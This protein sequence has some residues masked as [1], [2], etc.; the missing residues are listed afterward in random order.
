VGVPFPNRR[1]E[2]S[3]AAVGCFVNILP[4]PIDRRGDPTFLDL[5]R[6]V[7]VTLL[8]HHRHQE[9]PLE[10]I[11][12][13]C[14]P[15][16]DPGRN[17]L[18]QA[19]FTF[20][21]PVDLALEGAEVESSRAH[22]GGAQLDVFMDLWRGREGFVGELEYCSDLF[23][24]ATIER[25]VRNYR[26]LLQRALEPAAP[27]IPVS[28]LDLVHPSERE[29]V[30]RAWNATS[31][32]RGAPERLDLM[33]LEQA[34]RAPDATALR[35]GSRRW[36]YRELASRARA[37][38]LQLRSSGVEPGARVGLCM[39][40]SFE[41][42]TAMLATTM[43][44]GAYVPIDPEYPAHR[45]QLVLEDAR[46][47][48]VLTDPELPG[49]RW[50]PEGVEL[51]PVRLDG[52]DTVDE[53][54][55]ASSSPAEAAYVI[56]TSGSTGRPKGA[57]NSHR[58]IAN[59]IL[60][61]QEAFRLEPSDV[62]LQKTPYGF[63]VSVWE[64]FWPLCVGAQLE[65]A[66]PGAH[67]DPGALARLIQQAGV[68]TVHFV[69]S[70]LAAFL[71]HPGAA[72]CRTLRRIVCSGEAL[73]RE[74][75]RRCCKL[76]D[77][78][79]DNLYGPTEAA[80]DVSWWRC[81]EDLDR[82]PVPIGR[83]IAN[84]RLYVLDASGQPVPI[85]VPGELHIGGV[86]VALGYVNRPELTS[87]RFVPDP[88]DADPDARL[89]RTGDRVRW[90]GDGTL[91]FLGRLDDQVKL[92]GLRIEL[93]EIEAILEQHPGV[94]QS[95][96]LVRPLGP[97][98]GRLVAY[99]VP[100]E[101]AD[102]GI[103]SGAL[104]A[105]ALAHLPAY[106]VPQSFVVLDRL[107]LNA[108]GKVDRRALPEPERAPAPDPRAAPAGELERWLLEQWKELLGLERVGLRDH[109]FEAGGTSMT[110][111]QLVSRIEGRLG[112][113]LPL[114]RIFEHP[115]VEA[116]A[117]HLEAAG[118]RATGPARDPLAAARARGRL[119]RAQALRRP[120]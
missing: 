82:D 107:P 41:M 6:R 70:M 89:Y 25:L 19:G 10:R 81:R 120:R 42:V 5:L 116:L 29:L 71:E 38:A 63:D 101:R 110:A 13:R 24:E 67:R 76:L 43:A 22:A 79:L 113:E 48:V 111:A 59:R 12:A 11:V 92:R 36:S 72:R 74:L 88:F 80:V 30:T 18:V 20:E 17:P 31:V 69:P 26:H 68:T 56:F 106:M 60:W 28:R 99:V 21:P 91:E 102:G 62:V 94:R 39:E 34:A 93:G 53:L 95:A 98:E 51:L 52:L 7:R 78:E 115:T 105:H 66:P 77:A 46:P 4:V 57:A 35:M 84:T 61:M 55:P 64:V 40:R 33:F 27:A 104:H 8:G 44:G 86:Q 2:E 109:L 87:T 119:R 54:T 103:L 90:S 65:I 3:R 73:P 14:R 114:V 9:L 49:R 108:N 97:G 15:E 47:S 85:G 96:V 23:R 118:A 32:S 100:F 58:G 50:H 1:R 83:P 37:L 112:V 75:A 16:R 45:V 117:A